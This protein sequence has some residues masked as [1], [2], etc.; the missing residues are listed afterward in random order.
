M[1]K[2]RVTY[3]CWVCDFRCRLE[4]SLDEYDVVMNDIRLNKC[5]FFQYE[6]AWRK[7][8]GVCV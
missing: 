8:A 6:T 3:H 5:P 7:K 2:K 1:D 4:A